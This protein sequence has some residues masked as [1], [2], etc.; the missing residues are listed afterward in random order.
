MTPVRLERWA[1]CAALHL[2]SARR[3]TWLRRGFWGGIACDAEVHLSSR[4][5]AQWTGAQKGHPF[6]AYAANYLV[7]TD[8]GVI[9][10][11]EATRAIRQAEVGAA[12]TRTGAGARAPLVASSSAAAFRPPDVANF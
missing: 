2:P 12:R 7:D 4:S 9:V 6:F 10:D 5:A 11:V 8:H 3:K 1:A